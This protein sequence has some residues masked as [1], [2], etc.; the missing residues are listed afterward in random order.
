MTPEEK[1][2]IEKNFKKLYGYAFFQSF[3]I[4]IPVIVPFWQK[5]G[6]SLQEIFT[7]QGIFGFSLILFDAPAGYL[8]DLFGRKKTM[9]IGSIV[10]A[11]GFQILWFGQTF[12]DFA[13]YEIVV[14]VGLSLQSGCDIAILYNSLEKLK[15]MGKKTSFL[16]R[17]IFY[18]SIGEAVAS[19]LGGALASHSLE[20]PAIAN[21]ITG[22]LPLAFAIGIHEPTGQKLPRNSHLKNFRDIGRAVFGHSRLLTLI[23]TSFILY[24]F[25]TYCAVWSLQPYW[26]SRGLDY[27]FFGYLWAGNCVLVAIVS[28][29]A[30]RI[31]EKIGAVK[32]VIL[33]GLMPVIGY[34]GM[35]FTGGIFG[36]FFTLAFPVCRGLNQV[37]FQDA[38]NSRVPAEMRA[39][40]NSVGTLGMRA[41]FILF[42]PVIG[43]ALD[44]GGPDHAMKILGAS[45]VVIFLLITLPVL[46]QRKQFR[47]D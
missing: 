8:A 24:G 4:I 34:L 40:V 47:I 1:L 25:A 15:I 27:T 6:L 26:K 43:S 22:W 9:V 32:V 36:L 21:A 3:L 16:G 11:L 41:L 13:I 35:G 12:F 19:I 44:R 38:I 39:T 37:I 7:L 30:D 14:G 23:L 45:Y 5:K 18:V 42:G 2:Q 31:E 20:W 46:G 28:R 10:S 17:R 29:Y 33:I